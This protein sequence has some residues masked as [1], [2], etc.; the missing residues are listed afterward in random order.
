M[1]TFNG[2][3]ATTFRIYV[4]EQGIVMPNWSKTFQN[5]GLHSSVFAIEKLPKNLNFQSLFT[6]NRPFRGNF[7]WKVCTNFQIICS[8]KSCSDPALI[9][10]I[11]NFLIAL[12]SFCFRKEP[13]NLNFER[14][15]TTNRP[16]GGSLQW[17]AC[18]YFQKKGI[19]TR[20]QHSKLPRE[21]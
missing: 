14:L 6:S 18:T 21:A 4:Y 15:F 10:I 5:F 1:A 19:L 11:S 2:P 3:C 16:F 12:H 8:Q 9:K 17:N 20:Q 13:K 7:Q